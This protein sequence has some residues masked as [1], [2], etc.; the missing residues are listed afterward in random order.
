MSFLIAIQHWNHHHSRAVNL[1]IAPQRFAMPLCTSSPLLPS[2]PT[3]RQ[4]LICFRSLYVS[5]RSLKFSTIRLTECVLFFFF[6]K[7]SYTQHISSEIHARCREYQ[8]HWNNSYQ[9]T[10]NL[11]VLHHLGLSVE[12][13]GKALVH[14][15]SLLLPPPHRPQCRLV[16]YPLFSRV[17]WIINYLF[18]DSGLLIWWPHHSWIL[19]KPTF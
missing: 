3:P 6:G 10:L 4:P 12:T 13:T 15:F 7:G 9:P 8:S 19:I 5:L 11:L 14:A 17:L 16:W 18:S 1:P 2:A